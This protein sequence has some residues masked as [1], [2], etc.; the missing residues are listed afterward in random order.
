MQ[1]YIGENDLS[2]E[3]E[4][5]LSN[6]IALSILGLGL[7]ILSSDFS[8][9]KKKKLIKEI[10]TSERYKEAYKKLEFKYFPL[11]WKIFYAFAKAGN[12]TGVYSLLKIIRRI[13]G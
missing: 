12:A 7:N 11:H 8:A 5:A 6:R 13:I 4:D 10:I 3:Y 2:E 9:K 1:Q